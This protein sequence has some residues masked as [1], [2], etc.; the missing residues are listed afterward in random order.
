V[1]TFAVQLA[2][3][4]SV[5]VGM[6]SVTVVTF[7]GSGESPQRASHFFAQVCF[8]Q[9]PQAPRRFELPHAPLPS[10][11]QSARHKSMQ[12]GGFVVTLVV[13]QV[14]TQDVVHVLSHSVE[15]V[16]VQDVSHSL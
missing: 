4:A 12:L 13:V 7:S 3:H 2:L 5:Q 14:S 16:V 10:V 9:R 1:L 15:A 11:S 6:H 8:A